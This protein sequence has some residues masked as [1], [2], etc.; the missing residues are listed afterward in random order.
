M[1]SASENG[2]SRPLYLK[3]RDQLVE[4][5]RS[6]EWRPGQLIPNEFDIAKKHGVAQGTARQALLV[7]ADENLLVRRQ[8]HGT[9]VFEHTPEQV[10][11]RFFHLFDFRHRQIVPGSGKAKLVVAKASPEERKQLRLGK[12]ARVLRINRVRTRGG[13]PFVVETISV[14]EALFPSLAAGGDVPNT[15]YD[16]YQKSH[17]VHVV[18]AD[19]RITAVAAE[20]PT[21]KLLGIAKGT[22]LLKI[23]SIAFALGDKPVEWR[24][25]LCHMDMAYYLAHRK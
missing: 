13:K 5:I 6:W 16:V 10:L 1:N 21:A 11:R 20:R 24:V 15:L 14:H 19:E 8:G 9:T 18:R 7:L 25:S 2:N 22:P 4:R 17:R 23:D 12:S 3:V